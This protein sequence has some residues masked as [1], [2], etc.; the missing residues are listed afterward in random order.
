MKEHFRIH[1][2][3]KNINYLKEDHSWELSTMWMPIIS[4]LRKVRPFSNRESKRRGMGQQVPHPPG[5][6]QKR[7]EAERQ[8]GRLAGKYITYHRGQPCQSISDFGVSD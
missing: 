8:A 2:N 3:Q 7:V 4:K 6:F 1:T 5:I